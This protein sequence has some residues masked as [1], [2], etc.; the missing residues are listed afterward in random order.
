ME[1]SIIVKAPELTDAIN[2]LAETLSVQP[3]VLAEAPAGSAEQTAPQAPAAPLPAEN[4]APATEAPAAPVQAAAA[5]PVPAPAAPALDLGMISRA[6]AA[7]IDAGKL[8]E[9]MA[10]LK[11]YGVD[12]V[13]QLRPEQYGGF[14][15]EMRALGAQI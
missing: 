7:L 14:A 8:P 15:A 6:G 12:A 10:L 1:I 2:R 3:A 9:V 5:A 4:T 11:K 13:T